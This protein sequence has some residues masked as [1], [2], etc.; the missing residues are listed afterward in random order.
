MARL[1]VALDNT[2]KNEAVI[3][4]DWIT[5]WPEDF[6]FIRFLDDHDGT[7]PAPA[8]PVV[9]QA[10]APVSQPQTAAP[11]DPPRESSRD[12]SETGS[13]YLPSRQYGN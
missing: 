2:H 6:T 7:I 11:A 8:A 3:G 9:E 1:V 10:E 12:L 5:V 13:L 4:E